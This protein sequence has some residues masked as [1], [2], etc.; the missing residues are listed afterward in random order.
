M[1]LTLSIIGTVAGPMFPFPAVR[2]YE[3]VHAQVQLAGL[4]CM[5]MYIIHGCKS[6]HAALNWV[7]LTYV[8]N[9]KLYI[10]L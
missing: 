9:Y 2:M 7:N 6:G 3:K 10:I 5:C 4:A 1:M 8:F